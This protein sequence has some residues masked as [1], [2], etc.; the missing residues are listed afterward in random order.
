MKIRL[1]IYMFIIVLTVPL[2]SQAPI[3]NIYFENISQYSSD[4]YRKWSGLTVGSIWR[5]ELIKKA[6]KQIVSALHRRG[7]LFARIDSVSI[8][9]IS[10]RGTVL[11]WF[12]HEDFP[13]KIKNINIESDS[14]SSETLRQLLE[15]QSGTFYNEELVKS[16]LFRINKYCAQRGFPLSK[17]EI[18]N[19]RLQKD[20]KEYLVNMDIF[21]NAGRQIYIDEMIVSGN[22]LTKDYVIIR[23][24]DLQRG[25]LYDKEVVDAIPEKLNR[26]GFFKEVAPPKLRI[27]PDGR[28]II[29]IEVTE[30]NTTTFDGIVGYI[31]PSQNAID[32][33]G[34]FT[35]SIQL[36]LRNLFG[37][38]RKLE[39][40][41][42][43]PDRLSDEF[44]IYYEEPWIFGYSINIGGGLERLVRDTTYI[45]NTISFNG[46]LRLTSEFRGTFALINRSVI[47]DSTASADMRLARTQIW[48]A[49]IGVGYD[50]RDFPLNPR[51]GLYYSTVY[52]FGFKK[53]KGPDYLLREDKLP[54]TEE[55]QTFRVGLA[56]FREL[57]KNQVLAVNFSGGKIEGAEDRLQLSDHFWFGGS[58]TFRGYR[59]DQF[60]G[61]T[62]GWLNLEY[63]F[64]TGRDS[65]IFLFN[66]WGFY[67]YKE[68]GQVREDILPGFGIGLRFRSPLGI[69]SVDYG[70]GRGDSFSTG[71]IHFGIVNQ[72]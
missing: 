21:V 62:V 64:L 7:F 38:G 41:W 52:S 12:I 57:W 60:H 36:N 23:E 16:E 69:M 13:F 19:F 5:P 43:K 51:T 35:G 39:V 45:E 26:L 70:L 3:K 11:R 63:R 49:E 44:K 27:L 28:N 34:Y 68:N 65:R 61:T 8:K 46:S 56:Y 2:W 1:L 32:E 20:E 6:N 4:D 25:D 53:N 50:T 22:T 17:T 71:K 58:K 40:D 54:G 47:P 37:T 9:R 33:D 18:R 66:D 55:I 10:D 14:L 42:K 67:N 31:P 30:G 72:F 29:I 24:T 59:E 48:S 15:L